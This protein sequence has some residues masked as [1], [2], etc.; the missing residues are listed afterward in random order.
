MSKGKLP[1][2]F[3]CMFVLPGMVWASSGAIHAAE[4]E[5]PS[6]RKASEILPAE[7]L[8]GPHYR[9]REVVTADGYMDQFTVD[10]DYG[11]FEVT[12]DIA[13]RKLIREIYAITAL[14]EI[15]GTDAFTAAVKESATAPVALGK[16]LITNPVD[17]VTGI[18]KGVYRLFSNI[19]TGAT[20]TRDPSED[21]RLETALL[22]ST[23]KREYAAQLGVDV[24]SSNRVLHKELNSVGWAAAIGNWGTSLA[25]APV[26]G[27]A[28]SVFK[29]TRMANSV[30][31]MLKAEPP[32][33]LRQINAEKLTAMGVRKELQTQY[34][35]H[36]AFTP[37][38]DTILVGSLA[39]LSNVR[40]R[41][42][43]IKLALSADD[44]VSANFFTQMAEILRGYHETVS[45]IR[46]ITVIA[47]VVLAQAANG[48]V[49]VPYPLDYGVWTKKADEN[50]S[51][52]LARDKGSKG[53]GLFELW[54]TGT[55]SPVAR[56]QLTQRGV[57]VIENVDGRI[58]FVN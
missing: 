52:L 1:L 12:G 56:Q 26:G 30:N 45:P 14:H 32:P 4:Y 6:D 54:V 2:R 23:Y 22:L 58:D 44:E 39:S 18:P 5:I 29:T 15:K 7:I 38:H 57:K 16:N 21:S 46:Q 48:S 9:I 11:V 43:F 27:P 50:S 49:V 19:G 53:R 51:R 13:L 34:L 31:N 3:V 24:Y 17:T 33:R 28:V 42:A 10:S 47:P 40:G 41:D 20:S 36:P 25:L 37:R 8:K 55:L 35:D